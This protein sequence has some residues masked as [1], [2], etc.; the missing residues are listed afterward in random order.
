MEKK[1]YWGY[2]DE[3][4]KEKINLTIT[5][6]VI[7]VIFIYFL[8]VFPTRMEVPW[9]QALSLLLYPHVHE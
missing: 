6:Y 3:V 9:G 1:K 2:G 4:G 8:S 7:K 5:Y